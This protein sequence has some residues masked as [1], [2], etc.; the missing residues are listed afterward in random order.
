MAKLVHN[1]QKKNHRERSQTTGRARFGLLEKKKDYR[2]RAADY[3]KKQAALKVLRTKAA[4]HN[5]DEYY[6]A[7]TKRRTDDKGALIADRGNE[8]L[9]VQQV[10]LLKTQDANYVR[11]MRLGEML[12]IRKE[13]ETLEF[14]SK[15]KHT[16]FVD[17]IEEQQQFQPEVYFGTD[18]SMVGRRENRLR[19]DQLE[20]N[21][22]L[23][24]DEVI[25]PLYKDRQD[26][27]KLKAYKLMQRRLEREE[28][29]R[30]VE[31]KMEVTKELMKKGNKK[32]TVDKEGKVQFK[33][34]NQRKR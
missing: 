14:D 27:K 34:K 32:K 7:I 2:L 19:I 21:T 29:L 11:T 22:K 26:I 28:Q 33:W 9:S 16:V 8:V 24:A 20:S 17:S 18:K 25:D 13:R 12:K 23:V 3:H 6:H 31:A 10:K 5:P 30:T 15:G 4:A 1:V